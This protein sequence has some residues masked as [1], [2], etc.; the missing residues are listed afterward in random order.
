MR[1][2]VMGIPHA[3]LC[4]ISTLSALYWAS[5]LPYTPNCPWPLDIGTDRFLPL[6]VRVLLALCKNPL[7]QRRMARAYEEGGKRAILS[8]FVSPLQKSEVTINVDY[9][10]RK[11][12]HLNHRRCLLN[13]YGGGLMRATI[14]FLKGFKDVPDTFVTL[15]GQTDAEAYVVW[16]DVIRRKF[17][18]LKGVGTYMSTQLARAVAR[19]CA[20]LN[21][22]AHIAIKHMVKIEPDQK[23]IWSV[24]QRWV[25]WDCSAQVVSDLLSEQLPF[26]MEAWDI[27]WHYCLY[28]DVQEEWLHDDVLQH[29]ADC[30][31]KYKAAHGIDPSAR[32][33]MTYFRHYMKARK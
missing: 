31:F 29:V 15:E 22:D 3:L 20:P 12:T 2:K 1:D 32:R 10:V 23:K 18:A 9:H 5:V 21:E 6:W 17:L 26:T 24:I 14:K 8:E 13:T 27:S 30:R 25:G 19:C 33:I 16:V 11:S 4:L 28:K 7:K